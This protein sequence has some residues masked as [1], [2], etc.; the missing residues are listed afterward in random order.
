MTT[1]VLMSSNHLRASRCIGSN[2]P[3]TAWSEV[4]EERWARP[5]AGDMGATQCPARSSTLGARAQEE[6]P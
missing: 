6:S 1:R 3:G 2:G 5:D 4:K